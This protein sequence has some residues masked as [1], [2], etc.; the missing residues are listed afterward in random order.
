MTEF[1]SFDG[2]PQTGNG[3]GRLRDDRGERGEALPHDDDQ[4]PPPDQGQAQEAQHCAQVLH[5]KVSYLY[6]VS[7]SISLGW[8]EWGAMLCCSQGDPYK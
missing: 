1:S 4:E 7:I 5:G 8:Q 3:A 2:R 6:L